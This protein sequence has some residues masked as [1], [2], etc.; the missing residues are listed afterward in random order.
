M[1]AVTTT[2]VRVKDVEAIDLRHQQ[3]E[4]EGVKRGL[5]KPLQRRLP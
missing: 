2:G 1:L 4:H 3:V 5:H